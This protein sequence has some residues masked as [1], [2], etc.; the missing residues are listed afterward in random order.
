MYLLVLVIGICIGVIISSLG[1]CLFLLSLIP[2]KEKNEYYERRR[3]AS[4]KRTF[5]KPRYHAGAQSRH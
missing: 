5:R 3:K 4:I 2:L 1:F